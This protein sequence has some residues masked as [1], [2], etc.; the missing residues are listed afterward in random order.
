MCPGHKIMQLESEATTAALRPNLLCFLF[1]H[2]CCVR[3]VPQ[4]SGIIP[5]AGITPD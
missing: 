4:K 3:Y 2:F 5:A 1:G